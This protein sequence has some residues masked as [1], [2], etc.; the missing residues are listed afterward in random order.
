MGVKPLPNVRDS[1]LVER[2]VKTVRYVGD[3]RRCQYVVQRSKGVI[4]RQW[5]SVEYIDSRAG[6]LLVL[7]H[8]DQSS[9]VDNRPARRIDQPRR[10][11]HFLQ[12]RGRYQAARTA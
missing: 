7:Q 4:R 5:L 10:Q 2:L 3:M 9:L 12:F 1:I 6:D 11:L 8:V